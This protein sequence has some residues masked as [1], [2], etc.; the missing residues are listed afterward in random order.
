MRAASARG[1]P[2]RSPED[3]PASNAAICASTSANRPSSKLRASAKRWILPL[4]VF[5][6]CRTGTTAATG[7]PMRS[8]TTRRTVVRVVCANA[9]RSSPRQDEHQHVAAA[10]RG[11]ARRRS[12]RDRARC[13]HAARARRSMSCGIVVLPGDEQIFDASRDDEL[14]VDDRAQVSVSRKPSWRRDAAVNAASCRNSPGSRCRCD[15]DAPDDVPSAA[16]APPV[17][18]AMR[19]LR[20]PAPRP[21]RTSST[22]PSAPASTRRTVSPGPSASRASA[23]AQRGARLGERD[24]EA[25]PGEPVHREHHVRREPRRRAPREEFAAQIRCDGPAR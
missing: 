22:A 13:P 3:G 1:R 5:G 20:S 6:N 4:V 24:G 16:A 8:F 15:E 18:S 17:S 21:R 14:A 2:P 25:R 23:S 19:N 12:W 11:I 10:A 7:M 9:A